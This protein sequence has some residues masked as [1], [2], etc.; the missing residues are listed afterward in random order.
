[1]IRYLYILVSII[2]L[3]VI[4][5]YD[6]PPSP[7]SEFILSTDSSKIIDNVTPKTPIYDNIINSN[8]AIIDDDR[9][10]IESFES[11]LKISTPDS[12]ID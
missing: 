3:I 4:L 10:D 12:T 11:M 8:D 9:D 5:F 1:M 6:K 7:L 2:V